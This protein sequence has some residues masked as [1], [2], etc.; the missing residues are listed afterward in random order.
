MSSFNTI[1][2]MVKYCVP[3]RS[4]W[5]VLL[6]KLVS[7]LS[8]EKRGEIEV[9]VCVTPESGKVSEFFIPGHNIRSELIQLISDIDNGIPKSIHVKSGYIMIS[10]FEPSDEDSI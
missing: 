10:Y 6:L 5:E 7:F 3:A 4:F 1:E 9:L 2:N 8:P